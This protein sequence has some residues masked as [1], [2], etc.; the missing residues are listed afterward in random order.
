MIIAGSGDGS[1]GRSICRYSAYRY[2][3]VAGYRYGTV[4]SGGSAIVEV[5]IV[6][7][8][9]YGEA[10]CGCSW[11]SKAWRVC[12]VQRGCSH[13]GT[14]AYIV[15][16]G[17]SY[18]SSRRS[19]CRYSAYRYQTIAGYR[20]GAVWSGGSAISEV[21]IVVGDQHGEAICS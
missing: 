9:Q 7:G 3:T 5:R 11:C 16:S 10:I 8:D 21:R 1:S 17:S 14:A 2:Q 12:C 19:V 20:Y 18:G 6:V 15:S 13:L 4:C